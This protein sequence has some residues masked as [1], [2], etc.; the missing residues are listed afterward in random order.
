MP[1]ETRRATAV[2]EYREG[3]RTV[4]SGEG[5]AVINDDGLSI[6]PVAVEWLDADAMAASTWAIDVEVWPGRSLRLS[7]LARRFESFTAALKSARDRRRVAGML[8]HGISRP[9]EFRGVI[10][11]GRDATFLVYATHL[12]VVPDDG[13]PF[14]VPWGMVRSITRDE[15]TWNVN[16]EMDRGSLAFGAFGQMTDAFHRAAEAEHAAS[17]ERIRRAAGSDRFADGVGVAIDDAASLVARWAAPER[18]ESGAA[19]VRTGARIGLV[20]MLEIDGDRVMSEALPQNVAAFMLVPVGRVVVTEIISGPSAATY[21]FH[22]DV[23]AINADLQQL[24]FR[25]AALA[26]S[27]E[28]IASPVSE[29]RLAGRRLEPLKR[30]RAAMR[31]RIIH[32]QNWKTR[33]D[34]ILDSEA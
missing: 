10:R 4:A 11:P 25:R 14:Q 15:P 23:D 22:G 29:Y 17:V 27:D 31:A 5:E 3:G 18:R 24:H 6:G 26:A 30:L 20:E 1:D 12:T 9:K 19:L 34:R 32:D 33:L 2:F 21:V 28:E 16:L 13:D 7:Q 8:A